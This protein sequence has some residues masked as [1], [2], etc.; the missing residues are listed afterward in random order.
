MYSEPGEHTGSNDQ[1][2]V[3]IFILMYVA[4]DTHFLNSTGSGAPKKRP[5]DDSRALKLELLVFLG[6]FIILLGH[7]PLPFVLKTAENVG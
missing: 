2:S 5:H 1:T 3:K 6:L 7:L 4:H